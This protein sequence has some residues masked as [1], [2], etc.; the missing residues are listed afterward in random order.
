MKQKNIEMVQ[1]IRGMAC[2][3]IFLFHL[4][5]FGVGGGAK[6]NYSG[7][8]LSIFFLLTGYFLLEGTRK[9][10]KR[11]FQKKIIRI[12]PLYWI[13]TLLILAVSLV[14]PGINHGRNYSLNDLVKSLLF[15]PYYNSDGKLFSD[16]QC[17]LDIDY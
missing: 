5:G 3:A 8:P 6:A 13:L 14:F 9:T 2:I 10:E 16:S 12:V 1:V 4:P 7:F 17:W 11:Y 15:I